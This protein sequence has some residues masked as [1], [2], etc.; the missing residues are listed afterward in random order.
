MTR[1]KK[2]FR[3]S[4]KKKKAGKSD[5]I[6]YIETNSTVAPSG[7]VIVVSGGKQKKFDYFAPKPT[8]EILKVFVESLKLKE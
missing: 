4:G 7:K 1:F 5:L 3:K 8:E 6:K 2:N